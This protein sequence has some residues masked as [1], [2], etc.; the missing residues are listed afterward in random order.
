MF[1]KPFVFMWQRQW[2]LHSSRSNI[3]FKPLVQLF[4]YL[5]T[6]FDNRQVS[7]KIFMMRISSYSLPMLFGNDQMEVGSHEV[8]FSIAHTIIPVVPF[9]ETLRGICNYIIHIYKYPHKFHSVKS[10]G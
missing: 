4:H 8:F 10:K 1:I 5:C 2:K 7:K 6:V 3:Y 9:Q